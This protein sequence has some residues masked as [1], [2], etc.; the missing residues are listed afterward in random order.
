MKVFLKPC[1]KKFK[2]Y[3]SK[4][5]VESD[6]NVSS[7]NNNVDESQNLPAKNTKIILG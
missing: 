6:N 4:I 5:D 7:V 1:S 3:L 2:D